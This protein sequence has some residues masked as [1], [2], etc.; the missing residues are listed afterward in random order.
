[1][2]TNAV[3]LLQI[4]VDVVRQHLGAGDAGEVASADGVSMAVKGVEGGALVY[5]RFPLSDAD[6]EQIA[7]MLRERF[8]S[9]LEEHHDARGVLVFAEACKPQAKSYDAVVEEIADLGEWVPVV[10]DAEL[11]DAELPP[12]LAMPPGLEAL[13]GGVMRE[14]GPDVGK[15]ASAMMGG[16]PGAMNEMM[17]KVGQALEKSGGIGA[18]A[19]AMQG[20]DVG[21]IQKQANELIAKNKKDKP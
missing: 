3:A 10:A 18:L 15:L 7:V 11:G 2:S 12:N 21:A 20:V 4:S 1:M 16:D 17:A 5:T 6:G 8:E 13:L 9:L 19:S 14:L